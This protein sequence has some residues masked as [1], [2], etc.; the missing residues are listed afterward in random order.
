MLHAAQGR[1]LYGEMQ[2]MVLHSAMPVGSGEI[3]T[4][5]VTCVEMGQ[6][7]NHKNGS[8]FHVASLSFPCCIR[9]C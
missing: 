9:C 7:E 6:M 1:L 5:L 3:A 8:Q 4:T 2:K